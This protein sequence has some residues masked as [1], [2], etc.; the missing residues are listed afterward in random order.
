MF[1]IALPCWSKLPIPWDFWACS[2]TDWSWDCIALKLPPIS[3]LNSWNALACWL[4]PESILSSSLVSL[5]FSFLKMLFSLPPVGVTSASPLVRSLRD[6]RNGSNALPTS[7]PVS[8]ILLFKS[9]RADC[10][11]LLKD[12]SITPIAWSL[13]LLDFTSST[14]AL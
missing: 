5:S 3:S 8:L 11:S 2:T 13:T 1:W 9:L 10:P 14:A 7:S 6:L 4:N 12:F